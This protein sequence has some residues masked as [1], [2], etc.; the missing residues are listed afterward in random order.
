MQITEPH[1]GRLPGKSES[2]ELL[3]NKD[4][5]LMFCNIQPQQSFNKPVYKTFGDEKKMKALLC[6]VCLLP[7]LFN[8]CF[9]LL[10]VCRECI[11]LY[12]NI[13]FSLLNNST[14]YD[15]KIRGYHPNTR[16]FDRHSMQP[17][18]LVCLF[19]STAFPTGY[20]VLLQHRAC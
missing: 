5:A 8:N 9:L 20:C 3:R 14:K 12:T 7:F 2:V 6:A 4:N 13:L 16:T 15:G 19:A 17:K 18:A 1:S 10:S 11:L